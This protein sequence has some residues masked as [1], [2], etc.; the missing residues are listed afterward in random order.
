[1]SKMTK[2]SLLNI[3]N[4]ISYSVTKNANFMLLETGW[5]SL[6]KILNGS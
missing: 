1:M 6:G 4:E 2:D 3:A 5:P